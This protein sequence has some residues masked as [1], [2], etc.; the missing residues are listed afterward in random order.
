MRTP[1]LLQSRTRV[2]REC[3]PTGTPAWLDRQPDQ[4]DVVYVSEEEVTPDQARLLEAA[5]NGDVT[6]DEMLAHWES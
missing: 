1:S 4:A 5:L 6:I 2:I 3:M